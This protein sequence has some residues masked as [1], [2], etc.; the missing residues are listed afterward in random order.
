M[1]DLPL[2]FLVSSSNQQSDITLLF[3]IF[4]CVFLYLS[5]CVS[6]AANLP[7]GDA[8]VLLMLS[9]FVAAL[10]GLVILHERWMFIDFIGTIVALIGACFVGELYIAFIYVTVILCALYMYTCSAT[11][12]YIWR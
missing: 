5:F 12:V 6:A 8:T 2:A 1:V 9:S 3:T 4:Y 11:D 10:A 7:I